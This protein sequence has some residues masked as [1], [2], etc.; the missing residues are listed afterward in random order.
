MESTNEVIWSID[1]SAIN[2]VPSLVSFEENF[3]IQEQ[4]P[5]L[6]DVL[7][8]YDGLSTEPINLENIEVGKP[9][10]MKFVAL[11]D[12][13]LE[14]VNVS[15]ETPYDGLLHFQTQIIPSQVDQ[16]PSGEY[17]GVNYS[18]DYTPLWSTG[19]SIDAY[20]Y[21]TNNNQDD[22]SL[23]FK[24]VPSTQLSLGLE[25]IDENSTVEAAAAAISKYAAEAQTGKEGRGFYRYQK[26]RTVAEEL[27]AFYDQPLEVG[28]SLAAESLTQMLPY[29]SIIIPSSVIVIP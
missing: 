19:Y 22:Y 21:D 11:D 17:R 29:G 27:D 25:D 26:G 16:G 28:I 4:P 2:G 1:L 5:Q 3:S 8:Y 12:K 10:I 9:L 6:K 23:F 14:K 13:E 7:F 18:L 15:I 20:A 24:S